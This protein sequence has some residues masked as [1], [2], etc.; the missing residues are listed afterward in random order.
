M[1]LFYATSKLPI[2]NKRWIVDKI[3]KYNKNNFVRI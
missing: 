3:E 1:V 2:N